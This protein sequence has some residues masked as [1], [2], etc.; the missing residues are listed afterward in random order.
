MHPTDKKRNNRVA[1]FAELLNSPRCSDDDQNKPLSALD[2]V[3]VVSGIDG[4][5]CEPDLCETKSN[6]QSKSL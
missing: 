2:G 3:A 4:F 1:N 6:Y 5:R